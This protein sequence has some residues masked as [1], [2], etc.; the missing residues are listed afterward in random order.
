MNALFS[1]ALA[2]SLIACGSEMESKLDVADVTT[3]ADP[4][5]AKGNIAPEITAEFERACG[6]SVG[7]VPI[8]FGDTGPNAIG[9]CWTYKTQGRIYREIIIDE[10]FYKSAPYE[11]RKHLI[12]HEL[13]HCVLHLDHSED[14]TNIMHPSSF[15]IPSDVE[16]LCNRQ[17]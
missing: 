17:L 13:G 3:S 1:L 14:E 6:V 12:F 11:F 7:D 2:A 8:A 4:R 5:S 9:V 16:S 10:G 15:S